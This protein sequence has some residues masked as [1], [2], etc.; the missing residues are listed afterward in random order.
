MKKYKYL[1]CLGFVIMGTGFL[2][3]LP[4]HNVS[5]YQNDKQVIETSAVSDYHDHS[6]NC[7]QDDKT[8][9]Q[10]NDVNT[11]GHHSQHQNHHQHE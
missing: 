3:V 7:Y 10:Q 4:I 8:N 2:R 9:A 11:H 1:L 6:Q 5:A